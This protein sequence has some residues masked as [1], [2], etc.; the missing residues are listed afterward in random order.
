MP[1]YPTT[2]CSRRLTTETKSYMYSITKAPASSWLWSAVV[3]AAM[4]AI[5]FRERRTALAHSEVLVLRRQLA[6]ARARE[7]DAHATV[8]RS[9]ARRQPPQP[10]FPLTELDT[11]R[12][13][14]EAPLVSWDRG[15]AASDGISRSSVSDSGGRVVGSIGGGGGLRAAALPLAFWHA[16]SS[17][18]ADTPGSEARAA[19]GYMVRKTA[20]RDDHRLVFFAGIEGTGHH[21]SN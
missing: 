6:E 13:S 5:A 18:P 9:L 3:A 11:R 15:T 1:A 2:R 12:A 7:E 8:S 19:G 16:S 17:S 21:V 20:F 14:H 10:P 4:V